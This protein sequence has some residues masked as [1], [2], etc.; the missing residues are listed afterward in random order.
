MPKTKKRKK[1]TGHVSPGN[2]ATQARVADEAPASTVRR[3]PSAGG[4]T[5]GQSVLFAALLA[6]GFLGLTIFFTFFYTRDP[7]HFIYSGIAGL[8][9]LGWLILLRIRWTRYFHQRS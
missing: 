9:A 7:N 5:S 6:L 8:T 4:G 1:T 2:V 3:S